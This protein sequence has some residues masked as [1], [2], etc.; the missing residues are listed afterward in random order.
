[1]TIAISPIY[2]KLT[3]RFV[4]NVG[5]KSRA[6]ICK[7]TGISADALK[8]FAEKGDADALDVMKLWGVLFPN[9]SFLQASVMMD[10]LK[11][12]NVE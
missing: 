9:M 10:R 4:Y 7:D 1:M 5:P 8:A 12:E 2:I 6:A 11:F 3:R